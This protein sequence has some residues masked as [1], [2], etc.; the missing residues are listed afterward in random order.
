MDAKDLSMNLN[1][2][3]IEV[4]NEM[5]LKGFKKL[6]EETTGDDLKGVKASIN[7]HDGESHLIFEMVKEAPEEVEG[8][9]VSM[10]SGDSINVASMLKK[11]I[12]A[13]NSITHDNE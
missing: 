2:M 8:L 4:D 12:A 6:L 10:K 1:D 11:L 3:N 13:L 5:L 7:V 9:N